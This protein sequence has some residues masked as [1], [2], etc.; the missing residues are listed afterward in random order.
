MASLRA[1]GAELKRLF[2][3]ASRPA[4]TILNNAHQTRDKPTFRPRPIITETIATL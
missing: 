1:E 3:L 4:K 2:L